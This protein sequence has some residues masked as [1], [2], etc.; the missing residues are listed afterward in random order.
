MCN[1][2]SHASFQ[3]S[4]HTALPCDN[5][6][7][8]SLSPP[9]L[10]PSL[11][12]SFS[13]SLSLSLAPSSCVSLKMALLQTSLQQTIRKQKQLHFSATLHTE[14]RVSSF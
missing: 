7:N 3:Y 1:L 5:P 10:S 12:L 4:G 2:S 8:I 14:L 6:L 13:L 9:S 11:S